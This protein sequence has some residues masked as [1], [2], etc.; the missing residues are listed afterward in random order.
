MI[1]AIYARIL[2]IPLGVLALEDTRT[3]GIRNARRT[4]R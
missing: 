4:R 2:I 3:R 1:A